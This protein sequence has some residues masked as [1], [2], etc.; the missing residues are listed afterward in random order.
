MSENRS[1]FLVIILISF[2]IPAF[3]E[4][5]EVPF[6]LDD[7]DRLIRLGVEQKSLTI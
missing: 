2:F 1:I 4:T 6:T 3:A 5:V 7:R